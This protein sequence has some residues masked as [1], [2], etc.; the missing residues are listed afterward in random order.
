MATPKEIL[1]A[2]DA[3]LL[4]AR[5]GAAD[6]KNPGSFQMGLWNAAVFGRIATFTLQNLK[7]KVEG[8]DSWYGPK[9]EEMQANPEMR[10]FVELRNKIE[11]SV[12]N[13]EQQSVVISGNLMDILKAAGPP[14]PGAKD[15]FI[16]DRFGG[17]GWEVELP[18]GSTEKFYVDLPKEMVNA[19]VV[20]SGAPKSG[21]AHHL[22]E[23]YLTTLESLA[24]EA[25]AK[26]LP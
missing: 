25:R 12:T 19:T 10:Y 22:V 18:D 6:M 4:V 7:E 24:A 3:K 16:S 15:F 8:F 20:L 11:K 1:D 2:V 17:S 9:R 23:E 13:P 14:P 21:D 5:R 26:F